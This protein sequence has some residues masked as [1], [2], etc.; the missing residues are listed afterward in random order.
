MPEM[1]QPAPVEASVRAERIL[2]VLSVGCR[3]G[4][5]HVVSQACG[6]STGNPRSQSPKDGM[7]IL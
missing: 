5:L 4:V 1:V 6:D 3:E 2:T 7:G